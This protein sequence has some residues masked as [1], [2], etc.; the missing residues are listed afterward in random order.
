MINKKLFIH[1][2]SPIY[3][4][5]QSQLHQKRS[6][7]LQ[8][9]WNTFAWEGWHI[10][11][12]VWCLFG[13][14]II[15]H[16]MHLKNSKCRERLSLNSLYLA[17][18]RAPLPPKKHTHNSTVLKTSRRASLTRKDWVI[19]EEIR[20]WHHSQTLLQTITAPIYS[21]TGLVISPKNHVLSLKWPSPFS[22]LI[23]IVCKLSNFTML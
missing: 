11:P 7:I 20:Y 1:C 21:S 17:K 13:N 3:S 9:P 14:R 2:I 4:I 12:P 5:L 16:W 19:T 8:D 6:L 15:L 18:D 22:S 23:K 10:L